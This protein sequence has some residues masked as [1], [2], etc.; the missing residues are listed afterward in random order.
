MAQQARDLRRE[1]EALQQRASPRA[2]PRALGNR[3]RLETHLKQDEAN[4][5]KLKQ[6]GK[7]AECV[8]VKRRIEQARQQ[9]ALMPEERTRVSV[10]RELQKAEVALE[11]KKNAEKWDECDKV[12]QMIQMLKLE[13]E[14]IPEE[15][16]RVVVEREMKA[17]RAQ[18]DA[19]KNANR[20]GGLFQ[21]ALC[22]R[23]PQ[24]VEAI[25]EVLCAFTCRYR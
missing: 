10:G 14:G 25:Q 9:L 13:L 19:A 23:L 1:L 11:A 12:A 21:C 7:Y 22:V 8:E 18:V 16:T 20:Y 4:L 15:R 17:T 24:L 5:E 2:A 3:S 6:E